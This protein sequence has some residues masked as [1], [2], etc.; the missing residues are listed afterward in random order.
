MINVRKIKREF[1]MSLLDKD[2][3]KILDI[4]CGKGFMSKFFEK[5]GAKA[6]GID[7]KNLAEDSDNFKLIKGNIK[8]KD[9]DKNNDLIIASLILHFF[10]RKDALQIIKRIKSATSK[11]GYN[12]II[13]MSN[14][15]SMN[16]KEK[17]FPTKEEILS[18]YGGWKIE[19]ELQ[20]ETELEEHSNFPPHKHNLIFLI[21]KNTQDNF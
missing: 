13:C 4:G 11:G 20:D 16:R 5:K 15:D 21:L 14:L 12:L 6:I 8:K 3:K 19:K 17:F 18:L 2:I 9:F 10:E 1:L 7:I